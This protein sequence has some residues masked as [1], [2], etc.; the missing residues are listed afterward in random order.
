MG[1]LLVGVGEGVGEGV[2][3]AEGVGVEVVDEGEMQGAQSP[4]PL[5]EGEHHTGIGQGNK[6]FDK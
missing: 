6:L 4:F 1:E 3:V 5:G 2:L